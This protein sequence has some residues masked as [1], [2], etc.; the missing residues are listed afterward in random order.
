MQAATARHVSY[1]RRAAGITCRL[2]AHAVPITTGS[3]LARAVRPIP[4]T[5]V[6]VGK[7]SSKGAELMAEEWA[8]KLKRYASLTQTQIKPNPKNAKETAVA[9]QHEGERVLKALQPSDHVV[10]LDERGRDLSS[11]DLAKLLA[12]ASDQSWPSVVF[13][14]GGP[15]GHAPAV[16]ARG[17]DTIRLSKMVLNHQVAKVVLLEQLYR[18]WTILRGEPYHH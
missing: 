4:I 14:I 2:A 12:Q 10:L 15:F 5:L 13:C 17:N 16:R 3:S 11:E 18:A 7:G 6:T 1:L 9:V 8:D